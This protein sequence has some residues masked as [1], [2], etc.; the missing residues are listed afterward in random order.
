SPVVF[1]PQKGKDITTKYLLAAGIVFGDSKFRYIS[2]TV[3]DNRMILE[4]EA[5]IDGKYINGVDIIDFDDNQL[6]TQ[7][8][9]MVRPL[10]AVNMLWEKMGAQLAAE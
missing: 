1:T 7:F 10:Q 5:E 3:D 4:F 6:I 2:E 9:V 8:K